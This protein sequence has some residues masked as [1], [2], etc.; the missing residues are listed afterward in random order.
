MREKKSSG[1][2]LIRWDWVPFIHIIIWF[3]QFI[4]T[5]REI[6]CLL[7][8]LHSRL[9]VIVVVAAAVAVAAAVW[10]YQQIAYDYTFAKTETLRTHIVAQ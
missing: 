3:A 4:F 1:I 2:F 7:A 8:I 5:H 6:Y 9:P 10:Q